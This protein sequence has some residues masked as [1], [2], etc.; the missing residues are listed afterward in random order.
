V[1]APARYFTS[2]AARSRDADRP[3]TARR[4]ACP[5]F[6]PSPVS[7]HAGPAGAR[8]PRRAI[9][10]DGGRAVRED[11]AAWLVAT[12]E[13][14]RPAGTWQRPAGRFGAP[15]PRGAVLGHRACPGRPRV[16]TTG[17]ALGA[18]VPAREDAAVP[19]NG[20]LLKQPAGSSVFTPA[21]FSVDGARAAREDAGRAWR[22]RPA[23]WARAR[24][25]GFI[26]GDCCTVQQ[27]QGRARACGGP[28][29][30]RCPWG[31]P[32]PPRART[33][34]YAQCHKWQSA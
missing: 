9:F 34:R 28:H 6:R 26:S 11:A 31:H 13:E 22:E 12:R 8:W 14:R 19:R 29:G 25:A 15:V 30:E 2:G 33:R 1:K 5:G 10:V 27:V 17:P 21:G 24:R 16:P 23:G 3:N 18:A 4:L 7:H 32:L 20:T